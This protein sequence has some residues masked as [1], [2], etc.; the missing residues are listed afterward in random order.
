MVVK[1]SLSNKN[2]FLKLDH[3]DRYF[4][5][6]FVFFMFNIWGFGS[7][8]MCFSPFKKNHEIA[9]DGI[10]LLHFMVWLKRIK[11]SWMNGKLEK[12]V[13]WM[14]Y[15]KH[16]GSFLSKLNLSLSLILM[17]TVSNYPNDYQMLKVCKIWT[18]KKHFT[19]LLTPVQMHESAESLEF[20]WE[21]GN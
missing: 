2:S 11:L 21:F 1:L 7:F 16:F 13:E 6:S 19:I 8:G 10:T 12:W 9:I 3:I 20:I 15:S 17:S 18:Q 4:F 14:K 5:M